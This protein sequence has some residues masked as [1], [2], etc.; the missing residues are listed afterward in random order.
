MQ[1]RAQWL[2]HENTD[3]RKHSSTALV[4]N[5]I[6][7]GES[8][9]CHLL[10]KVCKPNLPPKKKKNRKGIHKCIK[11]PFHKTRDHGTTYK[12]SQ[13]AGGWVMLKQ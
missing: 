9:N 1:T 11:D 7:E 2:K 6:I 3:Q 4:L 12:T 5:G 13:L 10:S 8:F